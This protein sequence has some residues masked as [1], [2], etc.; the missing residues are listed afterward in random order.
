[1]ESHRLF[2]AHLPSFLVAKIDFRSS[3]AIA[4]AFL[5]PCDVLCY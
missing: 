4:D 2:V 5:N 1:M 3:S